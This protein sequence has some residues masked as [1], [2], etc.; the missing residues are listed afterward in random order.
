MN[1]RGQT[2]QDFA[3]GT[4]ILLLTIIGT[5]VFIQGGGLSVYEDPVTAIEQPQAD[6]VASYIVENYSVSDNRNTLRYDEPGGIDRLPSD[7]G[8]LSSH[9]GVNVSSDRRTD[10]TLSVSIVNNST[11]RSGELRPHTG[12]TDLAWG[13]EYDNQTASIA[14]RVISLNN[15]TNNVCDPICWLVVRAW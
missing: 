5:F 6:R 13:A 8:D 4:S 7:L 11:L 2:P 9:A 1:D 10:P 15:D 12:A 3:V 14:T